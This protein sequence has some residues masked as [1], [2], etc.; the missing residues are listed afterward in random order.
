MAHKTTVSYSCHIDLNLFTD[1]NPDM[2]LE[3][4][5]IEDVIQKALIDE[6]GI[7]SIDRLWVAEVTHKTTEVPDS[8]TRL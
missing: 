4:R 2:T 7:P 8:E 3:V 6:Y 5:N 1:P